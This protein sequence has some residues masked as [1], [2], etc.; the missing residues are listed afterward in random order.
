MEKSEPTTTATETPNPPITNQQKYE[1]YKTQFTRLKRAMSYEF[2]LE[3]IFIAYAIMEDRTEAILR[4]E[5]N[6]IKVKDG[7]FVPIKDKI[8]RIS[9]LAENKKSLIRRYITQEF[10]GDLRAWVY[11]RNTVIH[12][13]LKRKTTTEELKKYAEDGVE[14]CKKLSNK[15]NSYKRA[16]EKKAA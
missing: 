2:Y 13:L 3:A 5:G 10:C 8:N 14:L 7:R 15:A 6:S 1:N 4:Y 16:V 12:G 11:K 9:K